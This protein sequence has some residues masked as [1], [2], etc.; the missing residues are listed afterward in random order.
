MGSATPDERARGSEAE[1]TDTRWNVKPVVFTYPAVKEPAEN[2]WKG[3]GVAR[4]LI[5]IPGR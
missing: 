5:N 1:F 2:I 3:K 4:R